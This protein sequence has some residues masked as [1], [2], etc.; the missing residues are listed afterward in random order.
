MKVFLK[1]CI[2]GLR[3]FKWLSQLAFRWMLAFGFLGPALMKL[4]NFSSVMSWFKAAGIPFPTVSAYLA[5]GAES[6]GVL[7]LFFGFLTRLITIPLMFMM[8]V[9]ITFVHSHYGFSAMHNGF[10]I[11]L[12]YL[13]MLF[14]LLVL[15]PGKLSIDYLIQRNWIEK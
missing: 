11:P 8:I 14:N 12:Y 9:A 5:T 6:L 15:G 2:I 3:K 13:L 4:M 10:E 1:Q 7:C